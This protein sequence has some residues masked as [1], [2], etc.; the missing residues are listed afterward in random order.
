MPLMAQE[1]ANITPCL[2]IDLSESIDPTI[3]SKWENLPLNECFNTVLEIRKTLNQ[4]KVEKCDAV[5]L[6]NNDKLSIFTEKDLAEIF[7][8]SYVEMKDNDIEQ[9]FQI[10][11]S[12]KQL[13]PRCRL[14]QANI[15]EEL[16]KRCE[17][18][19]N[20]QSV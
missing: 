14:Y 2:N 20:I 17:S 15:D 9:L 4:S 13:C 3:I 16:C 7:Q 18:V 1:I 10:K 19:I 6:K 12:Q 11:P 8:V 5:L